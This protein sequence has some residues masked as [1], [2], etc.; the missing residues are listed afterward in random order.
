[1]RRIR[2]LPGL[3]EPQKMSYAYYNENPLGKSTGDCVIRAISKALGKTWD[4][5]YV[6]LCLEGFLNGDW[7][8]SDDTWGKYLHRNGFRRHFIP[9]DGLGAY[10][11]ADFAA[12]NPRGIFILSMPGKHVLCVKDG[13]LFDSW[14]SSG[15]SYYFV[16]TG[17]NI[18]S[19]VTSSPFSM[20]FLYLLC[21]LLYGNPVSV[22]TSLRRLFSPL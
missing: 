16:F 14:N 3:P 9:D 21:A 7:G 18:Y 5:V 6:G 10:T 17:A 19:S 2:Q 1:M 8:N 13:V 4:E 15:L 22:H 11:V 12:D 20:S